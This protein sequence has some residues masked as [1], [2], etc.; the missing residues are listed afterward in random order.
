VQKIKDVV[1]KVFII[2]FLIVPVVIIQ[3]ASQSNVILGFTDFVQAYLPLYVFVLLVV[4]A[5]SIIY[6][7]LPGI[8]FTIA[9]V[10]IIGWQLA[11]LADITG[12]FIGASVSF[13]L[14]KKYGYSILKRV[15]GPNIIEKINKIRLKQRN[16]V[17]VAIFLRFAGGGMLSDGLAWGASLIGFR[18]ASF[19]VGYLISHLMTS[20]PIFYFV[21]VSLS[22]NSWVVFVGAAILAWIVIYKFKGRYFE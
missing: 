15:I 16:Q 3:L 11:Y 22:F 6:P 7:P 1:I 8:A 17:E 9:S 21:A 14:G 13:F 18:Y 2:S 5:I 19:I 4:K 10:P 20:L 12:S